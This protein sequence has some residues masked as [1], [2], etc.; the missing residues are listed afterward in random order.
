MSI[1]LFTS[2]RTQSGLRALCATTFISNI[3]Y[4]CSLARDS[5]QATQIR[6]RA[7]N[8]VFLIQVAQVCQR[9]SYDIYII[10]SLSSRAYIANS[11]YFFTRFV[12][13]LYKHIHSCN[14][15]C[16]VWQGQC[17]Y[18]TACRDA[19]STYRLKNHRLNRANYQKRLSN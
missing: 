11:F 6:H 8:D 3:I 16:N 10:P 5:P 9:T 17:L 2:Q 1:S 13:Y 19:R 15:I 7:S 18:S 12:L 14:N 4:L